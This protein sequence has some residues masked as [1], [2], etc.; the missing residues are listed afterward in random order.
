[1]KRIFKVV[2]NGVLPSIFA[3][4]GLIFAVGPGVSVANASTVY[5]LN[6]DFCTDS[7]LSGNLGG[8][9]TLTQ[10]GAN[11]VDVSIALSNV[12]FHNT[13]AFSSF[14]FNLVGNPT[15]SISN[16]TA[17]AGTFAL[18]SANAGSI[19]NDGAGF[20]EYGVDQTGGGEGNSLSF[21]LTGTGLT[22]GSFNEL[23]TGGGHPVVFSVSAR[24][25]QNNNC[26]GV[27]GADSPNNTTPVR[28]NTSTD[29]GPCGGVV[30]TP[31]PTSAV[32]LGSAM[33]LFGAIARKRRNQ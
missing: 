30:R 24:N 33:I 26:T 13:N 1:M 23:S 31:E 28:V 15:I 11:N 16:I 8:T 4:A 12:I 14:A 19:H 6:V 7:C 21:R 27:I 25:G 29:S 3:L 17:A 2:R 18:V 22:E 20:F 5:T 9:V 32:L 10:A